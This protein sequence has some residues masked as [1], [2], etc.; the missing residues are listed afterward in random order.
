MNVSV[1]PLPS[2]TEFPPVVVM[3]MPAEIP[4]STTVTGVVDPTPL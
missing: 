3:V 2:V 4:L 1:V